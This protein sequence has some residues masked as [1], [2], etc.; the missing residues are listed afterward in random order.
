M[1]DDREEQMTRVAQ[2]TARL[3][4]QQPLTR[5]AAVNLSTQGAGAGTNGGQNS[6]WRPLADRPSSPLED[7]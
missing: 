1:T 4:A 3:A 5:E 7:L 6:R 2:Q